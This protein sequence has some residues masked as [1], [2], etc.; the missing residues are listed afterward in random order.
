M[1]YIFNVAFA[2]LLV[3]GL[4]SCKEDFK[5]SAPYKP[6]TVVY[7]L[8]NMGDTA[9]YIR[10][11]K[12]F[13]DEHLSALSIAQNADSNYYP[14]LTVVLREVN[15]GN[16][17]D[18]IVLT[19]VDLN[20]ENYQKDTGTFFSNVNYA[21]K[22]T[23][24]LNADYTYRL[25]ITNPD[26]GLSDSSETQIISNDP[27]IFRVFYPTT[28]DFP[29][30]T[31][32]VTFKLTGQVPDNVSYVEGIITFKYVDKNQITGVETH[33]SFDWA[34]K[35]TSASGGNFRLTVPET[36]FFP[37][38]YAGL[39][40]APANTDRYIDSANITV[41]AA[42][43]DFVNYL[44]YTGAQGGITADQIKPTFTNIMG[45][46]VYGIFTAR[47]SN[48]KTNLEIGSASIDS[49]VSKAD[50]S[51]HIIGEYGH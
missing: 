39:G 24:A 7:G 1:K 50:P 42:T 45:K 11:Q 33:R 17:V 30:M 19:R 4:A 26:N 34:F 14:N 43:S 40:I 48:T 51:Y 22:T 15:A 47:A 29:A 18:N 37:A 36:N 13:I 44:A 35:D 25:V 10:I 27:N 49:L 3:F 2:A 38:Y 21:Y 46:D 16:V 5:V 8:L 6:V 31:N 32:S 23:K 9:H 28:L 12:A 41:W 20:T